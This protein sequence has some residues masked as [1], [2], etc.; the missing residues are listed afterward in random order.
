[1]WLTVTFKLPCP[2]PRACELVPGR[3]LGSPLPCTC[4]V[5]SHPFVYG[6]GDPCG[7]PGSQTPAASN[8]SQALDRGSHSPR[9]A[10]VKLLVKILTTW[11]GSGAVNTSIE[12]IHLT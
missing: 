2:R 7:R 6:R 8:N 11:P 12:V 10:L 5:H 4:T 3:P 1:M 9:P